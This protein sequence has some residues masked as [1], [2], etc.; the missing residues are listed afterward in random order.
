MAIASDLS[1]EI[2][3]LEETLLDLEVRADSDRIESLIA[4]EFVE[5][6]SSG[7]LWDKADVVEERPAQSGLTFSLTDFAANQLGPNLVHATYR[8][9]IRDADSVRHSLRSSLWIFRSC[10][11]QI[12]FH[13]GTPCDAPAVQ[14]EGD[15]RGRRLST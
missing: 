9:S 8:A 7:R 10:R 11:I 2:R 3:E 6:G 15:K 5:F 1:D 12:V 14:Y 4:D 13:Q